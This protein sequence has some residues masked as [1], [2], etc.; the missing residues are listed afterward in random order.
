MVFF[1]RRVCCIHFYVDTEEVVT[2]D[3][4]EEKM[5]LKCDTEDASISEG[6]SSEMLEIEAN[7]KRMQ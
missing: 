4:K 1:Q 6:D 5:D 7:N 3:Q 2:D